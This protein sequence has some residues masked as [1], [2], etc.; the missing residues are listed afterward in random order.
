MFLFDISVLL[1]IFLTILFMAL[2]ISIGLWIKHLRD[3][4]KKADAEQTARSLGLAFS[5]KDLFG[6]APQLKAFEMFRHSRRRWRRNSQVKNMLRGKVGDTEV[7]QF[8]YSYVISTGKSARR[9]SQTIFFA[10][11]KQ[12]SL[13]DFDLRP[14]QWWHKVL[15]KLGAAADIN[16]PENPD[17]SQRF[18]LTSPLEEL[19]RTKFSPDLQKFLLGGPRIHLEGSNYYLI[20]YHPRKV[21]RG[22]EARAFF[23]RC[24]QLTELLKGEHKQD[25]LDLVELKAMEKETPIVL[26]EVEKREM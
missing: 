24:C 5:E 10:N 6:L 20:A 11:D 13:P 14:E 17:F 3:A 7:F 26:P 2:S 16:F 25:L 19:A 23:E 21:F 22:E 15:A 18:H 4:R 9:I 8:D 1:P 12:W